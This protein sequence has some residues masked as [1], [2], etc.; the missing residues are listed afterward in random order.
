MP[1]NSIMARRIL[2]KAVPRV[3][4]MTLASIMDRMS[5][6]P[7]GNKDRKRRYGQSSMF[8][9]RRQVE[10]VLRSTGHVR[11]DCGMWYSAG[12]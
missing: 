3:D 2:A 6:W 4:G 8:P 1:G 11:R 5:D 9:T 10:V 7:V 12:V